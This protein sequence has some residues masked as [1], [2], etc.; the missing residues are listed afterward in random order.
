[1][2]CTKEVEQLSDSCKKLEVS[3]RK[4]QKNSVKSLEKHFSFSLCSSFTVWLTVYITSCFNTFLNLREHLFINYCFSICKTFP[5]ETITVEWQRKPNMTIIRA[6]V[7]MVPNTT[8]ARTALI[9]AMMRFWAVTSTEQAQQSREPLSSRGDS[10]ASLPPSE[11]GGGTTTPDPTLEAG[12]GSEGVFSDMVFSSVPFR[13]RLIVLVVW[14]A[15]KRHKTD[16]SQL[17]NLDY[18]D[19]IWTWLSG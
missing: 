6:G 9:S 18:R 15:G 11:Y 13:D 16:P 4:I 2:H 19:L 7:R 12:R 8:E 3:S 17:N 14:T 10:T 5:R 1:M